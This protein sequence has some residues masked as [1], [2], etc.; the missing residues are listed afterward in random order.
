VYHLT[1]FS[2]CNALSVAVLRSPKIFLAATPTTPVAAGITFDA[3]PLDP[4]G[5]TVS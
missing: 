1:A 5:M 4:F 2:A 3:S